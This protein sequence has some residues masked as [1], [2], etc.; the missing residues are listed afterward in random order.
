MRL[1]RRPLAWRCPRVL[2]RV[3][4][5]DA[6]DAIKMMSSGEDQRLMYEIGE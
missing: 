2:V 3:E 4:Y 5:G 1:N 6:A